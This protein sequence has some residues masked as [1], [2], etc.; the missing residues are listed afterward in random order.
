MYTLAH[1]LNPAFA[2]S[3]HEA[4]ALVQELAATLGPV[5]TVPSPED[6]FL[7]ESGTLTLGFGSE[8]AGNPVTSLARL[9]EQLLE[10]VSAPPELL[11]LATENAQG[12]P[13][14]ATVSAL[15]RALAFYER[16][17]RATE[18]KAVVA[19]LAASQATSETNAVVAEL[20]EKIETKPPP[21]T[22]KRPSRRPTPLQLA[23]GALLLLAVAGGIALTRMPRAQ[24]AGPSVVKQAQKTL[25]Q[26]ISKGVS[27]LGGGTKAT[28]VL[29]APDPNSPAVRERVRVASES[30]RRTGV[31]SG[32]PA[33]RTAPTPGTSAPSATIPAANSD[34]VVT[35][36][37]LP[38]P[39]AAPSSSIARPTPPSS[40]VFS[41]ADPHVLPAKLVRSQL[42]T[43]PPP[44][45]LTGYFEVLINETG[46]VDEVRL[47][48]PGHRFHDRMLVSAAKA[49]KFRPAMFNG[50]PVKYRMRIAIVLKELA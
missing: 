48:S 40:D 41:P 43:A 24:S 18:I 19:R 28:I 25:S 39:G 16:P 27:A 30:R 11:A 36:E 37:D 12:S 10:G 17:D 6:V 29:E 26:A 14:H 49:W 46:T 42:P 7:D 2:R 38:S 22:V 4:V 34:V 5:L 23:G 50:Q 44:G 33:R 13:V 3:W 47:I 15:S 21:P 9:L 32:V 1:V 31:M 8:S 20:R 45:P 35:V